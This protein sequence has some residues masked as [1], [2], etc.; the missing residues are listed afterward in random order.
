MVHII[1]QN[2]K[3]LVY[4]RYVLCQFGSGFGLNIPDNYPAIARVFLKNP[5]I[6]ILDEAT[7]ALD[8]VTEHEIQ[9][10]LMELSRN[11]TTLIIAHRLSTIQHADQIYVIVNGRI[12]EHGTH[13]E[14]LRAGGYYAELYLGQYVKS[15]V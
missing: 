11:R 13:R 3:A 2:G 8:S 12:Q 14:L 7:S 4:Y 6:L 9:T 5:P 10:A 15:A 1:L